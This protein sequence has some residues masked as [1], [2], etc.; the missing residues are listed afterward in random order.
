MSEDN[1]IPPFGAD[2][3]PINELKKEQLAPKPAPVE[4]K[5]K[6]V[7]LFF[8]LVIV[9][10]VMVIGVLVSQMNKKPVEVVVSPS[11]SLLLLSPSPSS[12]ASAE[13]SSIGDR[14]DALEENLKNLD[15]D[16]TKL[17]FPLVNYSIDFG[18]KK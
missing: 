17:L 3:L 7:I 11:P 18:Q 13:F 15:L 8:C 16:Q 12:S 14:I 4:K 2:N 5:N 9:V 10:L 1:I 6:L